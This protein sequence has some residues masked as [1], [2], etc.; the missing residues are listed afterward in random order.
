MGLHLL[1]HLNCKWLPTAGSRKGNHIFVS[2]VNNHLATLTLFQKGCYGYPAMPSCCY[3]HLVAI[4]LFQE[5][6][7]ANLLGLCS[8]PITHL[9][10]P[11]LIKM[12]NKTNKQKT[13]LSSSYPRLTSQTLPWGRQLVYTNLKACFN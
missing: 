2:K 8:A 5:A 12:K 1:C 4:S 9:F 3:Y 13:C 7:M 6:L 11:E 10:C